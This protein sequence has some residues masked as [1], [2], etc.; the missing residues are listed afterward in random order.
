RDG[1]PVQAIAAAGHGFA[2]SLH[3]LRALP[4]HEQDAAVARL[5]ADEAAQAFDLAA[6]PLV[7][8]RLLQLADDEH[9]LLLTQHHIISDGWSI[10][11][12]VREV[13]AL[14]AAFSQGLPD[15]LP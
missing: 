6:G 9:V 3:D 7:R 11:I 1:A 10:G 4:G 15:P 12:M 2:L 5:R 13:S 14:Y 8:G